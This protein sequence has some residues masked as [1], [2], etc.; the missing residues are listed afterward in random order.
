MRAINT[1]RVHE[2]PSGD[3][4]TPRQL[5]AKTGER[6]TENTENNDKLNRTRVQT[7]LNTRPEHRGADKKL[8]TLGKATESCPEE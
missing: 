7:E 4:P 5:G 2:Q 6:N 1:G 8:Q 3:G